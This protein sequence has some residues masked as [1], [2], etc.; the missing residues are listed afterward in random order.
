MFKFPTHTRNSNG[1]YGPT[2]KDHYYQPAPYHNATARKRKNKKS[3]WQIKEGEQYEVFKISDE[4]YWICKINHCL[5]SIVQDGEV[6]L[7]QEE[8]RLAVFP[9]PQNSFDAWHG[10]PT[11]SD[12]K[13]PEPCLL[14]KWEQDKIISSH[15][16][17]KIE[18]GVL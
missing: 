8:E 7:G 17:R 9:V 12:N 6:V 10:W 11:N 5:F 16:R 18:R 2:T 13:K 15:I 14:D 1:T 4:P 3:R